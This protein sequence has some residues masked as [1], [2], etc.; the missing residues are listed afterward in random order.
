[1]KELTIY[2]ANDGTRFDKES[3]CL[4]YEKHCRIV[5][6][7][8]YPLEDTP[9]DDG[10]SFA[11]GHGYVQQEENVVKRVL[12]EV[13]EASLEVCDYKG[14]QQK[15]KGEDVHLSWI[16]RMLSERGPMCRPYYEAVMRFMNIDAQSRE[17]GQS[18]YALH[19]GEGGQVRIN[20]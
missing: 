18:Y 6:G 2:V 3:D 20:K 1:M 17:W 5:Y 8:L 16:A 9:K 15:L 4:E 19:P 14:T 10:C 12:N 7:L 13:L 11:N